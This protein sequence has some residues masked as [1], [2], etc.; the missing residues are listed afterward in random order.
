M[1][2]FLPRPWIFKFHETRPP[3]EDHR[4]LQRWNPRQSRRGGNPSG[5]LASHPPAKTRTATKQNLKEKLIFSRKK[6]VNI[7]LKILPFHEFSLNLHSNMF[8]LRILRKREFRNGTEFSFR[9][10][11]IK[12][13]YRLLQPL[14]GGSHVHKMGLQGFKNIFP[15]KYA[16]NQLRN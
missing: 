3:Y 14:L 15:R 10:L 4:A 2:Q 1:A 11:R 8:S 13:S 12:L 6:H 5:T 16:Y 9:G 7:K